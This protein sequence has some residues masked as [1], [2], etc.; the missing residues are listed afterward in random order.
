YP[1]PAGTCI[2]DY[3]HVEDIV[4][5]HVHVM[6]ALK[7]SDRRIYNLG[8]GRGHSVREIIDA[9]RRV[10]GADFHDADG[11]RRAGDPSSLYGDPSS[12]HSELGWRAEHT[13]IEATIRSAYQWFSKNPDGYGDGRA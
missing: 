13:D 11:P 5:A 12:I 1:T 9:A 6:G 4:A 10:A 7:A 2:R 8:V 3:I